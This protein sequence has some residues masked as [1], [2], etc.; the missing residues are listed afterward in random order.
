MFKKVLRLQVLVS[1][2][3]AFKQQN[4]IISRAMSNICANSGTSDLSH[5]RWEA[6][7]SEGINP[8]DRFDARQI[9]PLLKKYI[10]E[11]KIPFGRALVPG[12]GRGYDVT[13]LS[14]ERRYVLGL[15][16]STTA[17]AAARSRLESLSP[18]ECANK[19]NAIFSS[20]SFFDLDTSHEENKFDFIYDYTFLCALDPSVREDWANKMAA[21]LRPG[22]GELLT[23]IYP[24]MEMEGG[25]PFKVSMQLFEELLLPR[26]FEC[27]ELRMLPPELC[28]PGRDGTDPSRVAFTAVGRWRM[29]S[30][31]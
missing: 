26:N 18:S 14:H 3:G 21:L 8:G 29:K 9:S 19:N 30:S 15:D 4:T 7:W 25:P 11:D 20:E 12:C 16:I 10:E 24:I 13:A 27:L 23:L 2:S 22:T 17:L 1:I 28:H 6:M 5:P 31:T